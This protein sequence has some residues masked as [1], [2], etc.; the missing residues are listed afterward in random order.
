MGEGSGMS[1]TYFH[2]AVI[3][4]SDTKIKPFSNFHFWNTSV[5]SCCR[6]VI[7]GYERSCARHLKT[8][9]SIVPETWNTYRK[10]WPQLLVYPTSF[11]H[12]RLRFPFLHVALCFRAN[13]F[14]FLLIFSRELPGKDTMAF[15]PCTSNRINK[16]SK[17]CTLAVERYY[18]VM[19]AMVGF[20]QEVF[21]TREYDC[22][23]IATGRGSKRVLLSHGE[24]LH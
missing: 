17:K 20:W 18:P 19:R 2:S 7:N 8:G 4:M 24:V 16:D 9:L 15:T 3:S 5:H 21:V 14:L 22:C 23:H 6:I 11:I 1:E 13:L 10:H 12:I